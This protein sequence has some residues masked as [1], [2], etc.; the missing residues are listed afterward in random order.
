MTRDEAI[1]NLTGPGGTFEVVTQ[2]VRGVPLQVYTSRLKSMRELM[3]MADGRAD[4]DFIVQGE[5][6]VTFGQNN[7]DARRVARNLVERGVARGDRVALLSA[8]NPEW[9]V[10]FWACAAAMSGS[11]RLT[12]SDIDCGLLRRLTRELSFRAVRRGRRRRSSDR[13]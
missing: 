9:V 8:N 3:P 2:E 13:S 5:R 4:A 10:T 12:V 1:A 6:R 7:A 11:S